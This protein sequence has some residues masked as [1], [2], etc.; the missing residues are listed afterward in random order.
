MVNRNIGIESKKDFPHC[1]GS[2]SD[3]QNIDNKKNKKK[4]KGN[5]WRRSTLTQGR[6][7]TTIDA[8]GLNCRVRDGA[9]CTP[10]A[11]ATNYTLLLSNW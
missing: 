7:C 10:T 8:G 9:G 5:S 2:P 4:E 6:P 1:D 3:N 11:L